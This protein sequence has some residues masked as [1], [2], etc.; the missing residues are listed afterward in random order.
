MRSKDRKRLRCSGL[1]PDVSTNTGGFVEDDARWRT[2]DV[3]EG[4]LEYLAYVS[5]ILVSCKHILNAR[6]RIVNRSVCYCS[7]K[8]LSKDFIGGVSTFSKIRSFQLWTLLILVHDIIQHRYDVSFI[9][10]PMCA[11]TDKLI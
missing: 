8:K 1:L 7:R 4:V 5:S 2:F 3:F 6:Y 10:G 9:V 11:T